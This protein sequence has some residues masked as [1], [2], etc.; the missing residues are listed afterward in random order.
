MV[1]IEVSIGFLTLT[2]IALAYLSGRESG[3]AARARE[4]RNAMVDAAVAQFWAE[5]MAD[6][7][8]RRELA[9]LQVMARDKEQ[10]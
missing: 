8:R 10:T 9:L 5:R 6:Q 3:Y 2:A 4:D 1:W 7:Y